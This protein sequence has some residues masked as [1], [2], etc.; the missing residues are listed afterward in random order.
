MGWL[1]PLMLLPAACGGDPAPGALPDNRPQAKAGAA[2]I[3]LPARTIVDAAVADTG[4]LRAYVVQADG[5]LN[6]T[7]THLIASRA[8]NGDCIATV[9]VGK[10]RL[11]YL[12]VED[13]VFLM[14]NAVYW[15]SVLGADRAHTYGE[16][17]GDRWVRS[18]GPADHKPF[19]EGNYARRAQIDGARYTRG[20]PVEL[21]G[22]QAVPIEIRVQD[23]TMTVWVLTEPKH[24]LVKMETVG[25]TQPGTT[26]YTQLGHQ[27][28]VTAPDPATVVDK[29]TIG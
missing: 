24:Y 4:S 28:L 13:E 3:A 11:D 19:C 2:F 8:S 16:E 21:D 1:V 27:A 7:D 6:G 9:R 29:A 20:E 5:M 10:S 12:Q 23:V 18:A 26:T 14:G 25:G 15:E 22:K 17:I